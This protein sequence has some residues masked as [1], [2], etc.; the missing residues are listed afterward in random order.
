MKLDAR[1]AAPLKE[2]PSKE[3]MAMAQQSPMTA[4]QALARLMEGN[5]RY[6][7]DDPIAPDISRSRRLE[8]V[9]V[10]P[11]DGAAKGWLAQRGWGFL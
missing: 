2:G 5:A 8:V 10:G 7:S 3:D 11:I 4:D 1:Q 9:R 6:V